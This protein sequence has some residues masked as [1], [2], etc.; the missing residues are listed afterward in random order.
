MPRKPKSP[1]ET[2]RTEIAE[3]ELTKLEAKLTKEAEEFINS[4]P[5][6]TVQKRAS[7]AV[8]P[9]NFVGGNTKVSLDK[10]GRNNK[11]K[12]ATIIQ[13]L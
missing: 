9:S 4:R 8:N 13:S 11:T 12:L 7:S 1:Q 5:K 6:V 3:Q 10:Y 2:Y